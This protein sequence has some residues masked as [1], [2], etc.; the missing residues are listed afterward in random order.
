ML[1]IRYALPWLIVLLLAAIAVAMLIAPAEA[2]FTHI[3]RN[4]NEGWNAFHALRLR[5]GSPLYPPLSEATFINYP[6][7]S[8]YLAAALHPLFGDD[9]FAGRTLALI[10]ELVVAANI[11][12]S[13]R[14]LRVNW[15]LAA[16]A[17]LIFV[18]FAGIFFEDAVAIDDPQ[19]LGQ[20][21][22]ATGLT[23]L[24]WV[25][26][27]DWPTLLIV[28]LLCLLGGLAKQSLVALPLA[29]TVWLAFADRRALR[30]WLV[31]C[32]V[33]VVLALG[34]IIAIHGW[35]FVGQVLLSQRSFWLNA[36][37]FVGGS[38]AIWIAPYALFATAGLWLM[39]GEP[40]TR[41]IAIYLVMSLLVGVA[42]LAGNGVGYSALFDV[43]IAA[44]L[45]SAIFF[46]WLAKRATALPTLM[47]ALVI[48][49]PALPI[50]ILGPLIFAP[51]AALREDLARQPTWQQVIDQIAS[52][53]GDVACEMLSLCYWA[54]HQSVVDFFNFGQYAGLHPTFAKSLTK[55]IGA[56]QL[57]LIQEDGPYGSDRIPSITNATIA[58]GYVP[59]LTSPTLLLV[60]K[61]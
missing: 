4:Y 45:G 51:H 41:L 54:G 46:G 8:F 19:W 32:V 37:V 6:P 58:E 33:L 60:P 7:L 36:L 1:A 28:A 30:R 12:L 56:R 35:G 59:V 34:G 2:L 5:T 14:A 25:R 3:P 42:L 20:A 52:T 40:H 24:V 26:R 31:I 23:V 21:L 61:P 39:R 15:P 10:A 50:L 16:A 53:K 55:R 38:L 29:I 47:P 22:Q 49:A 18:V 27:T 11:A 57:A 43:T 13:A 48:V 44:M 17:G 9:I